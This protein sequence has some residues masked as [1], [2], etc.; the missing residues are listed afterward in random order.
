AVAAAQAGAG[1]VIGIERAA[2]AERARA[3]AAANDALVTVVQAASDAARLPREV[4]VLVSECLGLAGLGGAMIGAVKRAR[5]RWLKPGGVVIPQRVR[6]FAAPVED[7]EADALVHRWD[8][9]RMAGVRLDVLGAHVGHNLYIASF[10][11][12]HLLAPAVEVCGTDLQ[13][14]PLEEAVTG[15]A[16]TVTVRPGTLHGWALWFEADLP[17][18]RVLRTG[19]LD[20]PTVWQQCFA[21]VPARTVGGDTPI[22]LTLRFRGRHAGLD[23]QPPDAEGVW[24]DWDTS[25]AGGA[26]RGSTELS[27]GP[28]A[29]SARNGASRHGLLP[30]DSAAGPDP[31]R[32]TVPVTKRLAQ[33]IL[34]ARAGWAVPRRKGPGDELFMQRM[35]AL[36][37]ERLH[38]DRLA[39]YMALRD[40]VRDAVRLLRAGNLETGGKALHGCAARLADFANDSELN[41]LAQTWLDQAWAYYDVRRGAPEA[42]EARLR[43]A[44]DSDTRLEQVHG[45]HLMHIGRINTVHLWL[46]VQSAKGALDKALDGATA[47]LSYVNGFGSDLPL[48]TDW[49]ASA[50][51]GMPADLAAVMTR[52]IATEVAVIMAG[53]DQEGT[54]RA[55]AR[56]PALQR[57]SPD[58]HGEITD[59]VRTKGAWA[60]GRT[61]EFLV[62]V[63]AY[64]AAGRRETCLWDGA[65]LDLCRVGRELRP[66]AA[67]LFCEEVIERVEGDAEIPRQLRQQI[68]R[69]T[70]ESPAAPWVARTPA[71]RFHLVCMGLPRSGVVSLFTLFHKFR[72]ANEYAEAE[73]IRKLADCGRGRLGR[74]ALR[75]YLARR[76]REGALEMDAAS[77]L[78]LAADVLVELSDATRFVLPVRA[79]EAWFESYVKELLRVHERLRALGKDPPAWWRDYG[80]M[81]MGR[82]DWEDIATPEA[83]KSCL[84]DVARRFLAHWAEATGG[85]LESLPAERTFVVRTQDIGNLRDRLANF[86]GQPDGVLTGAG[87]SNASPPGPSPLDGLPEG[88]LAQA[89]AEICGPTYARALDRCVKRA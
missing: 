42:A 8:G 52:R 39:G 87:H 27:Y 23:H 37:A 30:A 75:A 81:L 18:A 71:R 20:A 79:P 49:S 58:V 28:H 25:I 65:L 17:H 6:V 57:L 34:A 11:E 40:A 12:R 33:A 19:P 4:D 21:P 77:F 76:D 89:A 31:A 5:D 70:A 16:T 3:L 44:M 46:R 60:E 80:A 82:F 51:A 83:R 74:D 29:A 69:L 64:L 9:A 1:T 67:R 47:S 54:T 73:T 66:Q 26:H 85:M 36:I 2:I 43:S 53:L 32:T 48:G 13:T 22:E 24:I 7:P 15:T 88:W 59:W 84:P 63:I 86:V 72:A 38:G 50:A 68:G 10:T 61:D 56:V 78:H 14:G 45:Y 62:H 41:D 55:L 35:Q